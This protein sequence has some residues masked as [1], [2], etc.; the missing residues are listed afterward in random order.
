MKWVHLVQRATRV[1]KE[2]LDHR[3]AQDLEGSEEK[4]VQLGLLG[5]KAHQESWVEEVQKE[6][7]DQL[8]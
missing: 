5:K 1:V 2:I 7:M 8:V 6:K 4:L 3:G